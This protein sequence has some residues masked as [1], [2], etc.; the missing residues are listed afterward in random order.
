MQI[1]NPSFIKLRP[2]L[3]WGL[4]VALLL[5]VGCSQERRVF[6]SS[7]TALRLDRPESF[8]DAELEKMAK[9]SYWGVC[10]YQKYEEVPAFG[11]NSLYEGRLKF[12]PKKPCRF[13]ECERLEAF[14]YTPLD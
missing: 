6:S 2:M 14:Y 8:S 4:V 12:V 7:P 13:E 9:C 3:I 11:P 10:I 5:A 1:Q